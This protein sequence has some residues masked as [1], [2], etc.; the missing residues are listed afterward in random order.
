MKR[1]V[2]IDGVCGS[3]RIE[4]ELI[5][6]SEDGFKELIMSGL[7]ISKDNDVEIKRVEFSFSRLILFFFSAFFQ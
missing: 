4:K 3:E 2:L 5:V 1:K 7:F 6:V